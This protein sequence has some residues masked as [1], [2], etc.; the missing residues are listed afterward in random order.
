MAARVRA[1]R[2]PTGA[3]RPAPTALARAPSLVRT[4]LIAGKSS[5]HRTYFDYVPTS[6]TPRPRVPSAAVPPDRWHPRALPEHRGH[7]VSVATTERP[8]LVRAVTRRQ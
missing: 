3:R 4:S 7:L 6:T 1:A 8:T 5:L 2:V